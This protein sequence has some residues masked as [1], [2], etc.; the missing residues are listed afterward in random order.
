VLEDGIEL[1]LDAAGAVVGL[2]YVDARKRLTLEE[3]VAVSY[4]NVATKRR[5]S[6]R[7]P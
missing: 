4:E 2:N 5:E 3:L 1:L 7:L 6:L